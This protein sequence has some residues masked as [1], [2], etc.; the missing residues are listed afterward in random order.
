MKTLL[1]VFASIPLFGLGAA[2]TER[3]AGAQ[4]SLAPP[5][6]AAPPPTAAPLEPPPAPPEQPPPLPLG[7]DEWQE[8]LPGAPEVAASGQWVYTGQ[9]G[10]VFM[11]YGNQ[12]VHEGAVEDAYPFAYVYY[13]DQGWIWVAAPWVWGWGAYPY[14]DIQGPWIF[15]WYSGLYRSGWGWGTY[16]GGGPRD[17]TIR[18]RVP[19][20]R[21]RGNPGKP[22]RPSSTAI[23]QAD[24]NRD[25]PRTTADAHHGSLGGGH[26]FGNPGNSPTGGLTGARGVKPETAPGGNSGNAAPGGQSPVGRSLGGLGR[27]VPGG[28]S[29][30]MGTRGSPGSG[31]SDRPR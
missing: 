6:S 27:A 5:P 28:A 24:A 1:V 17:T 11:P 22:I 9:Y 20:L 3:A 4:E 31:R 26:R 29:S 25:S 15:G 7:D 10:W 16:R 18:P 12:Y 23:P 19:P 2:G 30:F 8:P 13:P 14:F 21:P